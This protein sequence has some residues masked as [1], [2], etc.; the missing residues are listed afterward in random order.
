MKVVQGRAP[1]YFLQPGAHCQG[2]QQHGHKRSRPLE[3]SASLFPRRGTLL[4]LSYFRSLFITPQVRSMR[5]ER[6]LG[7]RGEPGA[8]AGGTGV[9]KD[10]ASARG[11][12]PS[13]PDG[14]SVH[15]GPPAPRSTSTTT[16][17][18]L[19]ANCASRPE[20]LVINGALAGRETDVPRLG[21]HKGTG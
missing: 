7:G 18:L 1:P 16:V 6:R 5:L 8:A 9:A 3:A 20:V 10:G 21:G 13:W 11:A 4:L 2:G 19:K 17:L 14:L 12:R 15:S